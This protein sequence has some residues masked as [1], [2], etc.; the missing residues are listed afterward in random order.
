MAEKEILIKVGID[1]GNA[2]NDLK[3]LKKGITDIDN[4][5]I[6]KPFKTIKQE[7]KEANNE[8]QRLAQQFGVNSKE[9]QNAAIKVGE[10]KNQLD[11]VNISVKNFNPD[12]KL[13]SLVTIGS[14]AIGTLQGMAGAITLFG[15]ES[16]NA[17]K[18]I[19]K[20]QA[21]MA[22]GDS[23]DRI[24]DMKDGFKTLS[25]MI[26]NTTVFQKANNAATSMA[27]TLMTAF[28]VTVNTTSTSF[29]ILKGAIAA[30][31]LGLLVVAIGS[32]VANFDS[33]K[34]AILNL[35]PGLSKVASFVGSVVNAVTDFVGATSEAERAS[36]KMI[37]SLGTQIQQQQRFL[38]LNADKYDEYTQRKMRADLEFNEF[39]KS[40]LEDEN[41]S[42]AEKTD[43]INQAYN[44]RTRLI[45]A[46]ERDRQKATKDANDKILEDQKK[47]DEEADAQRKADYQKRKDASDKATQ[48]LNDERTKLQSHYDE[49]KK[50]TDKAQYE[51]AQS[52]LNDRQKELTDLEKEY[53]EQLNQI[54]NIGDEQLKVL[55]GQLKRKAI[56]KK[57]YDEEVLKVS[58][59]T[60][61][62]ETAITEE[63]GI[64]TL[65]VEKKYNKLIG[66]FIDGYQQNA[67]EQS[68]AKLIADFDEKIKVAGEKQKE[69]LEKM[70][71]EQVAKLDTEETLRKNTINSETTLINVKT[72]NQIDDE[73]SPETRLAKLQSVYEAE[74]AFKEAKFQEELAKLGSD[75]DAIKN[76]KAKHQQE[77]TDDERKY[78][79]ERNQIQQTELDA[80]LQFVNKAGAFLNE[81]SQLFG[82]QS[83]AGK[84]IA[85]AQIVAEQASSVGKIIMN[86]HAANAKAIAA[87]PLTGGQPFVTKNTIK[88]AVSAGKSI[89]A[90][91]KAIRAITNSDKGGGATSSGL[92]DGG[93]GDAPVTSAPTIQSSVIPPDVANK[94]Q[95]VR[96]T[97][98][99]NQPVKAYITNKDLQDNQ[100][101]QDFLNKLGSF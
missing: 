95:D 79:K 44:K 32:I 35:I 88:G 101:S 7:I 22:L 63:K 16:E 41:L 83:K 43:Y 59:S 96:I 75:Q 30:T 36:E 34:K 2:E 97:N 74:K 72:E 65:E 46:A 86:T 4:T 53:T 73:D 31:G 70:K 19:A 26:Q 93:G 10:L 47:K 80:K 48:L 100:N 52:T 49:L 61:D 66:D 13:R 39:K 91:V 15:V 55:E 3:D 84:A 21:L 23:L 85:I 12:N 45:Q 8:A 14:G 99:Q 57:K 81:L 5:V 50:I 28:G 90:G 37:K 24:E 54:K 51:I 25:G 69:L 18:S 64:K 87:S 6:D 68:R 20:L 9:F 89:A 29:K 82:K 67:Y 78:S 42:E 17:Q 76:L 98:P 94:I 1:S 92:S 56:T 40:I 60:G 62:A 77:I 38:D 71:V 27:S 33:F 58:K 11:D